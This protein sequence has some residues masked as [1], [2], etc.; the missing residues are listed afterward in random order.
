[1]GRILGMGMGSPFDGVHRARNPQYIDGVTKASHV[2]IKLAVHAIHVLLKTFAIAPENPRRL[3]RQHL[4]RLRLARWED[5]SRPAFEIYFSRKYCTFCKGF[6]T[7]LEE[8]TGISLQLRWRHRLVRYKYINRVDR[9]PGLWAAARDADADA[10]VLDVGEVPPDEEEVLSDEETVHGEIVELEMV[11]LTAEG[12]MAR[13][14]TVMEIPDDSPQPIDITTPSP[15]PSHQILDSYINGLAY[16]IGQ[17]ISSPSTARA[18]VVDLALKLRHQ[19]NNPVVKPLPPTPET[20]PP[21]AP[22]EPQRRSP[23]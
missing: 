6:I 5:G 19:R 1:M 3:S 14:N 21:S 13:D 16:C 11:D 10:D 4:E 12:S 8:T 2:E 23:R 17:I 18:A 9:H 15:R 7:R 20:E 22:P